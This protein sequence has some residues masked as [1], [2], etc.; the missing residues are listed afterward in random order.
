MNGAGGPPV[1]LLRLAD[2]TQNKDASL[3]WPKDLAGPLFSCL[4]PSGSSATVASGH[5]LEH[6][7]LPVTKLGLRCPLLPPCPLGLANPH[8]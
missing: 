6:A 8:P 3:R 7:T 5:F 4:F 1:Q 2:G